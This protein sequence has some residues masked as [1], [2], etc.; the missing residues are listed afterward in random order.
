VLRRLI[1]TKREKERKE[2]RKLN[3]EKHYDM[4]FS[5]N[6]FAGD[7]IEENEIEGGGM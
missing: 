5:P 3:N 2:W 4:Y 6:N 1:V 7:K